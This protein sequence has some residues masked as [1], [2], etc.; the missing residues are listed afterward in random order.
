MGELHPYRDG[1]DAEQEQWRLKCVTRF[2]APAVHTEEEKGRIRGWVSALRSGD[3]EQGRNNLR[4]G[5]KFCCLG[6]ACEVAMIKGMGLS[7]RRTVCSD[8]YYG[9]DQGGSATVLPDVARDWFGFSRSDVYLVVPRVV[10]QQIATRQQ[11]EICDCFV[12]NWRAH[13]RYTAVM[14]NDSFHLNLA[15]IA[16]CVEFTYLPEDWHAAR[17]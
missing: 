11:E 1:E 13:V 2:C 15:E 5:D 10:A 14:L 6:V 3:Y 9:Q 12:D 8:W 16:D 4:R 17:G 7:R